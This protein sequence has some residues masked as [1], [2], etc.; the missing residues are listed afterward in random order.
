MQ[1]EKDSDLFFR[2]ISRE[3]LNNDSS[4][5]QENSNPEDPR[6]QDNGPQDKGKNDKEETPKVTS[7]TC[8]PVAAERPRIELQGHLVNAR[9][10]FMKEHAII[11]KFNEPC[12]SG[13]FFINWIQK[14]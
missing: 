9:I 7:A 10:E 4:T 5:R 3:I 14:N 13:N 12:P 11:C 6:G 2:S 8:K 1:Q